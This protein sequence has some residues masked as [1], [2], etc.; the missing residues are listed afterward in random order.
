MSRVNKRCDWCG[1]YVGDVNNSLGML[2]VAGNK[3]YCSKKCKCE[4]EEH[5]N[6]GTAKAGCM[7]ILLPVIGVLGTIALCCF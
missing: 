7:I 1:K 5:E 4:A 6:S 3:L 2:M